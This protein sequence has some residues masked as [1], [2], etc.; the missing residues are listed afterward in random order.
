MM[1]RHMKWLGPAIILFIGV[2]LHGCDNKSGQ[3]KADPP[4]ELVAQSLITPSCGAGSLSLDQ[5]VKVLQLTRSVSDRIRK[6]FV[7]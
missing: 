6:E 2:F 1:R 3:G 7:G 4:A 5:A